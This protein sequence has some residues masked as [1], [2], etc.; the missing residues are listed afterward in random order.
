MRDAG[1]DESYCSPEEKTRHQVWQE[2]DNSYYQSKKENVA[3]TA[4]LLNQAER[5]LEEATRNASGV[6]RLS[7]D[8]RRALR[9]AEQ[10]YRR[11]EREYRSARLCFRG[12]E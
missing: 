7:S 3:I 1:E 5:A 8:N 12:Y 4:R 10:R 2:I 6:K 11:A 9:V